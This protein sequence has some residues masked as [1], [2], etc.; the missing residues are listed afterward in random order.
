MVI[1]RPKIMVLICVW[2][3]PVVSICVVLCVY[4]HLICSG[5]QTC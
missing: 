5:P 4:C 1:I 2:S 3:A